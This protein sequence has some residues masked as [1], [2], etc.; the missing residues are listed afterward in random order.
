MRHKPPGIQH[1][2]HTWSG[3]ILFLIIFETDSRY[4]TYRQT[5]V[6]HRG[7]DIQAT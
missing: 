1:N 3:T 4:L 2:I 5:E 6:H 7:A